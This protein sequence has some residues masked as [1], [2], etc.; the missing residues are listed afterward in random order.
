VANVVEGIAMARKLNVACDTEIDSMAQALQ[1]A[2]AVFDFNK[3]VL[4]ESPIVREQAAKKLDD[5]AKKMGGLY[6]I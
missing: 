5:I 1:Q 6:G 2:V 4:R 3:D